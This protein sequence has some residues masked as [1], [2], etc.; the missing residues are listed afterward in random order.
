MAPA[1]IAL[2][3]FFALAGLAAPQIPAPVTRSGPGTRP[4]HHP[5]VDARRPLG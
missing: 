5:T 3:L 1:A 4:A 2:A